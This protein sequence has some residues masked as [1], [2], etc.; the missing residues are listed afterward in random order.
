MRGSVE[1]YKDGDLL[2]KNDNLIMDEA[3]EVLAKIMV[4]PPGVSAI[5][6]ASSILDTSNYTVQAISFA[7][8]GSAYSENAHDISDSRKSAGALISSPYSEFTSVGFVSSTSVSS[9]S[10]YNLLPS[11]PQPEDKKLEPNFPAGTSQTT[12]LIGQ[13]VNFI[14]YVS[15][16]ES[17]KLNGLPDDSSSTTIGI[18]RSFGCY[19]ASDGTNYD[20]VTSGTYDQSTSGGVAAGFNSVG[21]MDFRGFVTAFHL[22]QQ[23]NPGSGLIVSANSNFSSIGEVIYTMTIPAGDLA[24]SNLYGGIYT[25]GLWSLDLSSTLNNDILPPFNWI[26]ASGVTDREYSLFSKISLTDNICKIQ[27]NGSDAGIENYSDLTLV[28]RVYFV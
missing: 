17:K 4:T 14:Q 9:Y 12:Q 3:S 28:W 8:D 20:L 26:D 22:S 13:N 16:P 5:S 1:I 2:L 15:V 27:D 24:I 25:L 11:Y 23:T 18:S 6:S 19:S 21:S 10:P 7:K